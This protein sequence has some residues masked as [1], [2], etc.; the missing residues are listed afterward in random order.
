MLAGAGAG[1]GRAAE[2]PF[3]R[4]EDDHDSTDAESSSAD[5]AT[6]NPLSEVGLSLFFCVV[7]AD[8]GFESG[9]LVFEASP[10]NNGSNGAVIHQIDINQV[11]FNLTVLQKA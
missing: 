9:I 1:L 5:F 4:L 7:F 2:N 8:R 3:A 11:S 10:V 6:D